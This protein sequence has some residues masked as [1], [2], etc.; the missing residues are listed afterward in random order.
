MTRTAT[1]D[2]RRRDLEEDDVE[3]DE[4]DNDVDEDEGPMDD[5][6][7]SGGVVA[8]LKNVV[9]DAALSVLAPVAKQAA[10]SAAKYAVKKGPELIEDT[11]MPMLEEAG[12]VK[13]L[14]GKAMSGDGAIGGMLSKFTG[15]DDDE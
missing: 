9:S 13:G 4:F 6:G 5:G 3:R 11:V 12:G 2:R 7:S 10:T 14:A 1:K 15:G 8:E